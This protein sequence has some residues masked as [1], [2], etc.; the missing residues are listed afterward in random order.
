M[1]TKAFHVLLVEDNQG[2]A[3][4]VKRTLKDKNRLITVYHADN[5]ETAI[6]YLY[7]RGRFKN[8]AES[9]K[10]HLILLDLR[11]PK[12]DGMEVLSQIKSDKKLSIIPVVVL[13]TSDSES[14][15]MAAYENRAN[16]Y[17][18]KPFDFNQFVDLMEGTKAFWMQWNRLPELKD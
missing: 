10:P 6:D 3:E 8:P 13:T 15:I 9:P 4:L 2:H 18:V 14:D 1:G 12:V 5:G 16:S 17:L 7:R 11:M